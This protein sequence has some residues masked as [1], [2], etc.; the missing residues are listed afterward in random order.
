MQYFVS[1]PEGWTLGKTWPIVV[2]I[3]S[4]DREFQANANVFVRARKTMPFIIVAPLVVTNGGA[5]GRT[6]PPYYYTDEVWDEVN[7]VGE[8]RFDIEGVEAVVS[9]VQRMYNG[10]EKYFVTGWEAGGHTVWAMIF[11][12]PEVLRGAAPVTPNYLGRGMDD[13]KFSTD[14]SLRDLPVKIFEA[15]IGPAPWPNPHFIAQEREAM[16]VAGAHGYQN[17]SKQIV[18]GKSHGPLADEVLQFFATL[19][20]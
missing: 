11:Q 3:E 7:R 12:H 4:A 14:P 2:V 10:E 1:A 9:D 18:Q 6:S 8:F 19:I 15:G 20:R 17:V 5:G 13:E 16:N